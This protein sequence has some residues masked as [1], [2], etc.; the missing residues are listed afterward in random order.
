M[1]FYSLYSPLPWLLSL[2]CQAAIISCLHG[3]KIY[4]STFSLVPQP[5][6]ILSS[7]LLHSNQKNSYKNKRAP[8]HHFQYLISL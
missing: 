4:L 5:S 7:R 1:Y 3:Y 8:H 2:V 6:S